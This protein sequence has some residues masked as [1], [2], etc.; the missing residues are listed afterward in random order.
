MLIGGEFI[1][2]SQENGELTYRNPSATM[3]DNIQDTLEVVLL[4]ISVVAEISSLVLLTLI[5]HV[6]VINN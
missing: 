2:F 4:S 6:R 5:R 1:F 3:H